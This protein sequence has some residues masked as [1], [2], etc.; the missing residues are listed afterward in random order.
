MN[1]DDLKWVFLSHSN[2]DFEKVRRVRNKLES[3][4]F[5]PILFFLK[6]LEAEPNDIILDLIKRE[7]D[8]RP[9]FVLCQSHNTQHSYW[10][11]KEVEYIK[12]IQRPYEIINLDDDESIEKGVSALSKR[13]RVLILSSR[14]H[15]GL[16][17]RLERNG[18]IESGIDD[19][20]QLY[21]SLGGMSRESY[22]CMAY[23]KI[24]NS[25][26]NGYCLLLINDADDISRMQSRM[27]IDYPIND[28]E[29]MNFFVPIVMYK[30]ESLPSILFSATNLLDVSDL[31]NDEKE[32]AIVNHLIYI[33][34]L[35]N[36]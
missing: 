12:S 25:L 31:P 8:A 13:S 22:E 2:K 36:L 9:R 34:L 26:K 29:F 30:Q 19:N 21:Q 17:A 23:G 1:N 6:C 10:V 20:M 35:R 11:Q 16:S 7:I 28:E 14:I 4:N 3:I 27:A 32:S 18:F 5:F 24:R 33:D 15:P